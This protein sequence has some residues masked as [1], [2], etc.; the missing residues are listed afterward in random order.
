MR[1]HIARSA[2]GMGEFL[3][4]SDEAGV[5]QL[6]TL[7]DLREYC[8]VVAGIVGEML[9][10]LF[11]LSQPPLQGV[12]PELRARSVAFGEALQLVNI[13]KDARPDALEGRRYLPRQTTLAEVFLLART[14][15]RIAAEYVETLRSA[16]ASPGLVAFNA[17]NA[18]LAVDTLS[19]LRDQGPG[20]KLSRLQVTMVAAQVMRAVQT[21]APLFEPM[22][23]E[24]G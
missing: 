12:A 11:L 9:T 8:Y 15:L 23:P 16:G 6:Q 3:T 20:A 21:G 7:A 10:E 22:L 1:R 24:P 14:D 13:L 5:L 2:R 18:R 17:L 4:R 19:V